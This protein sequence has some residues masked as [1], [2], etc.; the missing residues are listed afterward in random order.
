MIIIPFMLH[1][2][3]IILVRIQLSALIIDGAGSFAHYSVKK[4][5]IYQYINAKI[6]D[7]KGLKKK[8]FKLLLNNTWKVESIW[9]CDDPKHK[10]T[11]H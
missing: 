4:F 5:D 3:F 9:S 10:K 8:I 7:T 2:A 1:V 11:L 6:S